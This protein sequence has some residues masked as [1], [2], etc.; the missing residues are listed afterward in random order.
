MA[1]KSQFAEVR[2]REAQAMAAMCQSVEVREREA[3]AI[4]TEA[5]VCGGPGKRGTGHSYR[6]ISL[7]RSG[8]ERH[9]P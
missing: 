8:K 6:S 4:A 1:T 9:R 3:Q 7:W 5:S 2:E